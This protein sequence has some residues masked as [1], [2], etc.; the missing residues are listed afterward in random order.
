MVEAKFVDVQGAILA[1]GRGTRLAPLTDY[2]PK[3]LVPL[4][5]RPLIEYALDALSLAGIDQIGINLYHLGDRIP[6][7]LAHRGESLQFVQEDVLM[8]TGGGL[9]G[10]I[11]SN[12]SCTAVSINGD[13][14]FDFPIAPA[15]QCHRE[16]GAASTLLVRRVPRDSPFARI[17]IDETGRIHR[18]AELEGP[19]AHHKDL[20]FAAYTGVQI[21]EPS[22]MGHSVSEPSDILRTA[23][24]HLLAAGKTIMASFVPDECNWVDVG[25]IDRYL[26]AHQ[27]C[28]SGRL[29][30]PGL[31]AADHWNRRHGRNCTVGSGVTFEGPSMVGN[32]VTLGD[33]V[34]IGPY[35]FIGDGA[36]INEGTD[37][38]N[39]VVWPNTRVKGSWFGAVLTPEATA[40]P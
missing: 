5:G 21:L 4:M 13:A 20:V 36:V 11:G 34:R 10:I 38:E 28:L 27:L 19:Q 25:S 2:L 37:L 6:P 35:V 31:P 9:R 32:H 22:V 39:T 1:A 12:P 15:I 18:I 23:H 40:E 33:G 3:P 30:A 24:K 8:G 7:A 26:E 14:V 29:K 16:T 17:G